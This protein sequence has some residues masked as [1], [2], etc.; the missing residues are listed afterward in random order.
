MVKLTHKNTEVVCCSYQEFIQ[1]MELYDRRI[2]E[3]QKSTIEVL[4]ELTEEMVF[5]G[6][7]FKGVVDPL[8]EVLNENT[9]TTTEQKTVGA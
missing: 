7:I 1:F 3:R 5:V 4:N 8:R 2:V 9:T 6:K